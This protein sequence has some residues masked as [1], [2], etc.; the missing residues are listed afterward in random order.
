MHSHRVSSHYNARSNPHESSTHAIR[1]MTS[2]AIIATTVVEKP[3]RPPA[4]PAAGGAA[5]VVALGGGWV[6]LGPVGVWML[7]VGL[8]VSVSKELGEADPGIEEVAV[9][10]LEVSVTEA[11]EVEDAREDAS[12]VAEDASL[13]R[14]DAIED[15]ALPI[16]EALLVAPEASLARDDTIED[17]A[18]EADETAEEIR[19]VC[20]GT[21]VKE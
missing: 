1:V 9:M 12:L 10:K 14:D 20:A 19:L 13:E 5:V 17:C 15:V 21:M 3:L 7:I 2:K 18:L 11:L 8:P 6:E 4:P 16:D